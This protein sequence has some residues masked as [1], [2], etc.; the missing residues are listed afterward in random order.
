MGSGF[1]YA[2]S[3]A[4]FDYGRYLDELAR[5]ASTTRASSITLPIRQRGADGA[6][7]D[8]RWGRGAYPVPYISPWERSGEP[9]AYDGGPPYHLDRFNPAYWSRLRGFLACARKLGIMVELS[10]FDDC[11]VR[12]GRWD[13]SPHWEY[14]PFNSI[15][16]G[17][18]VADTQ[19]GAAEFYNLDNELVRACQAALIEKLLAETRGFENVIF[20]VCNEPCSRCAT[21]GN[22][23]STGRTSSTSATHASWPPKARRG[24]LGRPAHLPRARR[25]AGAARV[26]EASARW[27]SRSSPTRRRPIAARATIPRAP[28]CI[29]SRC[30][31]RS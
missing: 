11:L 13:K 9:A 29:A 19:Q 28:R 20:E 2:L 17:P 14:H 18:I 4:D 30:G 10:I 1:Y 12:H 5:T 15:N 26:P 8:W 3:K 16:G 23:W 21:A 7:D 22:G 25:R 27:R 31:R 6:D 24:T